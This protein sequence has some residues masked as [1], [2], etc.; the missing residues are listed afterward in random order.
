[1]T[2]PNKSKYN[3]NNNNNLSEYQKAVM[4]YSERP[5]YSKSSNLNK[6][7]QQQKRNNMYNSVPINTNTNYS[8]PHSMP[9]AQPSIGYIQS[10][11]VTCRSLGGIPF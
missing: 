2:Y 1:M 10:T 9:G 4:L 5:R 8:T 7:Y 6:V 11:S 3:N